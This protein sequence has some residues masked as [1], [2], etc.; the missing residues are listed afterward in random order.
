MKPSNIS[1]C[2]YS[3][4]DLNFVTGCT[5]VSEGCA[6]CYAR[7]IYQRFGRDFSRVKWHEDK[8]ARLTTMPVPL[9]GNKRGPNMRP[10]CFV[11]DTGDLFH[12]DI[13][14]SDIMGALDV[15]TERGDVTWAILTKRVERMYRIVSQWGPLPSNIWLGVTAENQARA[16][17]RIP[18]LLDTP[19]AV[20]FVSVEPMLGPVDLGS[21]MRCEM[22]A[23]ESVVYGKGTILPSGHADH[24]HP[25][26][27]RPRLDWVICGGESGPHR[28]PFDVAWAV[29]LYEQCKAAGVPFFYKQGNAM[30]P[31]QDDELPGIGQ[32]KEWPR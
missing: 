25:A 9:D 23:G 7:A 4:G 19:A 20:R 2:D 22:Y 29:S 27:L 31:G 30:R 12:G 6:N 32:V 10:I 5:P 1:W 3:G 15:M 28:R 14:L 24:Y 8:L 18:I 21:Y 13:G 26:R 16:D 17:E 11:C